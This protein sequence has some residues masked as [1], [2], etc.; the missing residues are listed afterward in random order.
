MLAGWFFMA[1]TLAAEPGTATSPPR[2][3]AWAGHQVLEG[4]RKIPIYGDK[5]THTEN[6]LIAEV[7]RSEGRIDILQKICRIEVRPIKNV[8]AS[9]SKET[10]L[11]LPKSRLSF[12]VEPDGALAAQPWTSGWQSEDID[13]DGHPGATVQIAGGKCPGEVYATNQSVSRLVKGRATPDGITGEMRAQVKQ[14]I[15]GASS[16]CLKLVA[17]DSDENQTGWFA[18]RRVPVGTSCRSLAD[19]PWPVQAGPPAAARTQSR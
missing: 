9:M 2:V 10:V 11:R 19:K 4:K 1:M 8:T 15:L 14:K 6:F 16:I 3:E 18:Y 13:A 7:R 17:G 12:E 5:E